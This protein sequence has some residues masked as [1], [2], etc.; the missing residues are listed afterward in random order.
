MGTNE[1][2]AALP[3]WTRVETRHTLCFNAA[4]S[5]CEKSTISSSAHLAFIKIDIT[6]QAHCSHCGLFSVITIHL[7]LIKD[8]FCWITWKYL[9]NNTMRFETYVHRAQLVVFLQRSRCKISLLPFLSWVSNDIGLIHRCNQDTIWITTQVVIHIYASWKIVYC[10]NYQKKK[11]LVQRKDRS[12]PNIPNWQ[13]PLPLAWLNNPQNP[14]DH[15]ICH[16]SVLK[17]E[18]NVSGCFNSSVIEYR[19]HLCKTKGFLYPNSEPLAH[20]E[21]ASFTTAPLWCAR[22]KN[23]LHF[24]YNYSD[25]ACP[26]RL[27]LTMELF[28]VSWEGILLD[29]IAMN[30]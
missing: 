2:D 6:F 23:D 24:H 17:F 19:R 29:I 11:K 7:G 27:H 22:R 21:L 5:S 13:F 18:S 16:T 10:P 4:L 12:V 3:K 26:L 30:M 25:P 28:A 1:S 15:A 8:E 14:K 20:K 9:H